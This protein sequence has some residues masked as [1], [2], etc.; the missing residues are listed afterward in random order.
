MLRVHVICSLIIH[1]R[2]LF[3]LP[4]RFVPKE[5]QKARR[6][7]LVSNSAAAKIYRERS[8]ISLVVVRLLKMKGFNNE[9]IAEMLREEAERRKAE[10]PE[11]TE[12]MLFS[13]FKQWLERDQ[14]DMTIKECLMSAEY[15]LY[16][17]FY[18][19]LNFRD[20]TAMGKVNQY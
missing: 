2:T 15:W 12:S 19:I 10:E 4:Y 11:P 16:F 3:F 18:T 14:K 17:A 5:T 8:K 7:S 13:V 9:R 20:A 1:I 6:F